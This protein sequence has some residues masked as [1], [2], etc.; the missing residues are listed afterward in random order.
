MDNASQTARLRIVTP[1]PS[2]RPD[3]PVIGPDVVLDCEGGYTCEC[4][5]CERERAQL[6]KRGVRPLRRPQSRRR[7]A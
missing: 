6:V 4:Q 5:A 2:P 3:T 1:N 7:A